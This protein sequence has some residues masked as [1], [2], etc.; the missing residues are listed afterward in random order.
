M[1][2]CLTNLSVGGE[3]ETSVPD[4]LEMYSSVFV[5]LG[6]YASN[7]TLSGTEGQALADY[8]NGGGN[9]YMEGG[10]TWYYDEQTAVHPM[11][12]ITGTEDGSDDL[13]T[14]EGQSGTFTEGMVY[15]YSGENNWIDHISPNG[16]GFLILNNQSPSYGT[17]VANIG[18]T[19]RTIGC[20]H[21]F[22]GMDDGTYSKD[23]LM[24]KYLEFFGIDAVWVGIDEDGLAENS[25][26]V[27]P[28]PVKNTANIMVQLDKGNTI[29]LS[30]YNSTGKE[31]A[32]KGISAS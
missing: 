27:Y 24:Y 25:L 32:P 4:N 20:S 14:I 16:T 31:V 28:N 23:Y 26:Q 9:L 3:Y 1:E 18:S 5:S 2:T 22:G 8:L 11:F 15:T 21:E 30:L 13:G 19:Y 6:V 12:N 29:H 10:D 17:G 7:H